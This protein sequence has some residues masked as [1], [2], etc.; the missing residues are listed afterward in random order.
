[1]NFKLYGVMDKSTDKLVSNITNPRHKYW[2]KRG[3]AENAV[4]RYNSRYKYDGRQLEVVEIECSIKPLN[5][6]LKAFES[7]MRDATKEEREFIND[8][9]DNISVT[10]GVDFHDKLDK[11]NRGL[12]S[13]LGVYDDAMTDNSN[14]EYIIVCNRHE[15]MFPTCLL[16]WGCK[17]KDKELRRSFG[18]YTTNINKCERYSLEELQEENLK[19]PF[20]NGENE[21][22][23][24][25]MDDVIIKIEDLLNFSWLKTMT[26]AY[27]S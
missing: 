10:I 7:S 14:R 5:D 12:R 9:L 26:V 20:Y 13:T 22:D 27:K 4:S 11:S 24:K 3:A 15:A 23:F 1:M 2:E 16:F 8:Y 25:Q 19:I 6:E 18:G 17:T 21:Y